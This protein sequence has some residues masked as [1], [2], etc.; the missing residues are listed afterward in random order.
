MVPW[1]RRAWSQFCHHA[2][3]LSRYCA[4]AR[5]SQ[6]PGAAATGVAAGARAPVRFATT[7]KA[8]NTAMAHAKARRDVGPRT[9]ICL[10]TRE[11]SPA[12]WK[13]ARRQ[14]KPYQP[15]NR[16]NSATEDGSSLTAE[17][18]LAVNPSGCFCTASGCILTTWC[19][20]R[21][22]RRGRRG[23]ARLSPVGTPGS[24]WTRD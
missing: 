19:G 14:H 3:R 5:S 9:V 10:R 2:S 24:W 16:R 1:S 17:R 20:S 11:M 6:V 21:C 15:T 22:W 18:S 23:T 8:V 13:A 7:A 4:A 12:R